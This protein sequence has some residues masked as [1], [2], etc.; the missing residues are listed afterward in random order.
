[1]RHGL[2]LDPGKWENW[3]A[4]EIWDSTK[5]YWGFNFRG[6]SVTD[7]GNFSTMQGMSI[8]A[9]F[10]RMYAYI[11]DLLREKNLNHDEV[12]SGKFYRTNNFKPGT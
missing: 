6:H 3:I 9:Q 12:R 11:C 4:N 7:N 8:E 10:S 2:R 5:L 1:M